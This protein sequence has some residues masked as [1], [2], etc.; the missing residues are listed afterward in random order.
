MFCPN[1][2]DTDRLVLVLLLSSEFALVRV[3]VCVCVWGVPAYV[4][5]SL[6]LV[7]VPLCV[8]LSKWVSMCT[9]PQHHVTS[10]THKVEGKAT[11]FV[12]HNRHAQ[13][14]PSRPVLTGGRGGP[15]LHHLR[16]TATLK[17]SLTVPHSPN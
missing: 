12:H 17:L 14:H 3:C 4:C 15:H 13:T 7:L 11:I 9:I 16:R 10:P 1:E 2:T 5:P 8:G 6:Y